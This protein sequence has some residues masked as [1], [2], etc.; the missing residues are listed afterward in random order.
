MN[1][2]ET[3][4]KFWDSYSIKSFYFYYPELPPRVPTMGDCA[5]PGEGVIFIPAYPIQVEEARVFAEEKWGYT[6]VREGEHWRFVYLMGPMTTKEKTITVE[7]EGG[8]VQDVHGL[9]DGWDYEVVDYD[10]H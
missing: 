2:F 9:P 3:Y 1:Q 6:I 5:R 7:V 4:L 8:V 10:N